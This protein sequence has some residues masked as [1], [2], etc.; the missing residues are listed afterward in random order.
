MEKMYQDY[1][2]IAEFRMVYI[3]EAHA[4]DGD[5]PVGIAREKEINQQTTYEGR[6]TTAKMLFNDKSLTIPCLID[7]MDNKT[8][9]AYSAQPDRVF[10]VRKD[11]RLA[12]AADK[13]PRGFGP[14]VKDVEKWLVEFRKTSKEPA[15]P[16]A[17]DKAK[18]EPAG[19]SDGEK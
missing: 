5:R 11:G 2:D 17:E 8:N 7:S 19:S 9:T 1:K 14:G 12:V 3:R 10:L 6:C 4:A 13:G 16:I 15:L 18:K